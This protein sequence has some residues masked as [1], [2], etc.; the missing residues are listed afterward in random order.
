[1]NNLNINKTGYVLGILSALFFIVCTIW[2]VL[3]SAPVLKELHLMLMQIAYPGFT[4]TAVGYII[5]LVEAFVYGYII[6]ALFAW[7]CKK[8]CITSCEHCK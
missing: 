4:L 3:I 1:M 7:L 8:V 5:G 6:G 2:G